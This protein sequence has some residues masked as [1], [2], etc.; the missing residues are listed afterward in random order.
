MVE[1]LK[2]TEDDMKAF[3]DR[4]Q[5]IEPK[6][7]EIDDFSGKVDATITGWDMIIRQNLD[8]LKKLKQIEKD[9][10]DFAKEKEIDTGFIRDWTGNIRE[11]FELVMEAF[12]YQQYILKMKE[13]YIE[14]FT[15]L[16][17]RLRNTDMELKRLEI[18]KQNMD[19][20]LSRQSAAYERAL[21][22]LTG[23]EIVPESAEKPKNQSSK[24]STNKK[25]EDTPIVEE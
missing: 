23:R 1:Q 21:S 8:K 10:N 13:I 14:K 5:S 2:P 18:Q 19:E 17:D 24:I 22:F 3:L 25:S 12:I 9:M 7:D 11:Q 20:I 6:T 15:K 16:F 4:M